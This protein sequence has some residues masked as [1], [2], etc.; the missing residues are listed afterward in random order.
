MSRIAIL[1][2]GSLIWRPEGLPIQRK[3]FED[4]PLIPVEF[5]RQSSDGRVTLVICPD[6]RPVRALWT[7]MD[8]TDLSGAAEALADREGISRKNVPKSIG[9]WEAGGP[10]PVAIPGLDEWAVS[11]TIDAVVWTDLP[12]KFENIIRKPTAEQVIEYLSGLVG[13][14]RDVAEEYVRRAPRQTDTD[15]RR[16][17]EAKFGWSFLGN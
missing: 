13:A 15:Y 14:R 17:I 3:W 5:A 6:A 16:L 11:R 1:G 2:W 12:C 8:I 10:L 4:G 7:L 9:Q